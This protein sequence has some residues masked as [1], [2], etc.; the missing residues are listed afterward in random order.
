MFFSDGKILINNELVDDK[1]KFNILMW[2]VVG[3]KFI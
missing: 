3:D 2:E 1:G